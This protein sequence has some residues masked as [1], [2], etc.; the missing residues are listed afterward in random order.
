VAK[1]GTHN[2][3][4]VKWEQKKNIQNHLFHPN[5]DLN[6]EKHNKKRK[7]TNFEEKIIGGGPLIGHG[8][9]SHF[10]KKYLEG[11]NGAPTQ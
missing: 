6:E 5:M 3:F 2:C 9:I 7:I 8:K 10:E 11:P 1:R 4:A